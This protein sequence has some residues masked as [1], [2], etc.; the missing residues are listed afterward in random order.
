MAVLFIFRFMQGSQGPTE[1]RS[2]SPASK[3][4]SWVG[5]KQALDS[6]ATLLAPQCILQAL[7]R[8]SSILSLSF[9]LP[10]CHVQMNEKGAEKLMYW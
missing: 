5:L 9:L 6:P 2:S 10:D 7:S 8:L 3:E 4:W 1:F